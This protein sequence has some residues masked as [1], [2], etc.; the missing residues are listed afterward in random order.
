MNIDNEITLPR[1]NIQVHLI[2][3]SSNTI[4]SIDI[5]NYRI[6]PTSRLFIGLT[7]EQVAK[8]ISQLFT[9]CAQSHLCASSGTFAVVKQEFFSHQQLFVM[10]QRCTL[11]WLKEHTW[12]LWQMS[13]L[14]TPHPN[15]ERFTISIAKLLHPLSS[16]RPDTPKQDEITPSLASKDIEHIRPEIDQLLTKLYGIRPSSFAGI[17]DWDQLMQWIG[18]DFPYPRLFQQLTQPDVASFGAAKLAD[19]VEDSTCM[20]RTRHLLI[21]QAS[22]RWGNGLATRVLSLC[23]KQPKLYWTHPLLLRQTEELH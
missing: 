14:L 7:E 23:S 19:N 3:D 13:E 5:E 4:T 6:L 17:K 1:N 16:S 15:I 12:Q 18:S 22:K 9:L 8:K 21:D 11:E 10:A 20:T 2:V